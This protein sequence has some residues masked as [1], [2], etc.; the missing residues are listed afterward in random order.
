MSESTPRIAAFLDRDGVLN[1]L[2]QRDGHA[3]SPRTLKDFR[4]FPEVA[5][6]VERLRELGLEVFV[7]TNQPD[8]ARGLMS[9]TDLDG[10][11]ER[12]RSAIAPREIVTCPHDDRDACTC[13]KPKPGM[14][15][16]LAK[17]YNVDL[18]R[19][20]MV[21]DSH[22]DVEAA[23][24][25]GVRSIFVDRRGDASTDADIVVRTLSA[26]VAHIESALPVR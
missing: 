15:V 5:S 20:F 25:A 26:A 3:V 24:R 2:V 8:I 17:K 10:M 7:V 4:I 18:A 16:D 23:R 21:G 9:K 13:R 6:A 14:L 19:S 11:H 12:L 22:K 1:E